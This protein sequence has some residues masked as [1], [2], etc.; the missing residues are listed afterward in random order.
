MKHFTLIATLL[1]LFIFSAKPQSIKLD[2][3]TTVP[4]TIKNCGALFSYDSVALAPKKYILLTDFQNIGLIKISG[5]QI[6]LQLGETKTV[7]TTNIMNYKGGGYTVIL[8]Y[9]TDKH[10][11]EFDMESGT[12]QISKGNQKSTI[13]IHGKSGCDESKQERNN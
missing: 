12:I 7:G 3:F 10:V 4:T 13:K 8:S 1:F 6:N 11:G 9:V 5:K 2:Y